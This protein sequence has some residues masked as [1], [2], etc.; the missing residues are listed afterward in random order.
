MR[1]R[2]KTLE[3]LLKIDIEKDKSVIDT[4]AFY[5]NL[6]TK[7]LDHLTPEEKERDLEEYPKLRELFL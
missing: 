7:Y 4:D 2:I 1:S 5:L 3:K 6:K